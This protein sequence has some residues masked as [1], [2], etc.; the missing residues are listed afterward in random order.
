MA[1]IK[2]MVLGDSR[3]FKDDMKGVVSAAGS[4]GRGLSTMARAAGAAGLVLAGGLAVGMKKSLDAAGDF[5]SKMA[6]LQATTHG[7]N[8]QMAAASKLAIK[9]GADARLPAVSAGDAADAMLQLG[10]AGFSVQKSM[11]AARG[12]L[13]LAT[14]AETDGA[15]AAKV[16][17]QNLNAFGLK[18]KDTNKIVDEM[19]GFMNAT[20]TDFAA[21]ADS[22][23][24]TAAISH[25]VGQSF[26]DTTTQ[27]TILSQAGIEGSQAGTGLRTML[28]G[29]GAEG[30]KASK[31]FKAVGV[32]TVDSSGRFVGMRSVIQQLTP[33][34]DKMTS[35]QRLTFLQT[36]F[37]KTAMNQANIVLSESIAKYDA[38]KK[39][40]DRKG[41]ADKLAA[42]HMKGYKGALAQ[43]GS[44]LE[45]LEIT[46][47]TKFL[48]VATRVANFLTR[49]ASAPSISVAIHIAL[50]GLKTIAGD[51][52]KA[53]G[54]AL[55]GS[56]RQVV[57]GG[58]SG[59]QN[60]R[61][62]VSQ[63]LISQLENY[64]WQS[65]MFG[66]PKTI[67]VGGA[68][69]KA[70]AVVVSG[71][72]IDSMKTAFQNAINSV[73][74]KT[75]GATAGAAI[76]SAIVITTAGFDKFA[77]TAMA[78]ANAHSGQFAQLGALIGLKVISTLL[79]PSFWAQHWQLI[80]GIAISVFPIGRFA[81]LGEKLA[82]GAFGKLGPLIEPLIL[83]ALEKLPSKLQGVG[84]KLAIAFGELIQNAAGAAVRETL[85]LGSKIIDAISKKF[86]LLG[87][88]VKVLLNTAI[89]AAIGG[90]ISAAAGKA[91]DL[92][93]AIKTKIV[94][95]Y[96]DVKTAT[97][98]WI[99]TI[100]A[101]IG[102]LP[103][104]IVGALG[105]LSSLLYNEGVAILQGFLDGM[106]SKFIDVK[107]FLTHLTSM[108]PSWKG[109]LE[110][111]RI[112]LT[113]QGQAIIDGL[114]GGMQSRLP[115]L[116]QMVKGIAASVTAALANSL[117]ASR[118]TLSNA[119]S[120]LT[121]GADSAF[122][123]LASSVQT[124]TEKIISSMQ[125]V[126]DQAQLT[127]ALISAQ[128]QLASAQA[129]PQQTD[130]EKT[131][132]A[133]QSAHDQAGLD[134]A[135]NT[136]FS[137]LQTAQAGGDPDAILAAQQAFAD[138][139]YNLQVASLNKQIA[140]ETDANTQKQAIAD[141]AAAVATA[142]QAIIDAKTN[143]DLAAQ[144]AA[145]RVQLDAQNAV[146]Q[147]AF[148]TALAA[149]QAHLAKGHE[150]YKQANAAILK[151]FNKYIPDYATAGATL[152]DA[153]IT[154]L[155]NSIQNAA[156]KAGDISGTKGVGAAIAGAVGSKIPHLATG[157]L[158]SQTGLAVVHAGET[159]V[160][161]GAGGGNVNITINGYVSDEH[162]EQMRN[163]LIRTGRRTSGGVLGGF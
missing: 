92:A 121:S 73:D 150:T 7:T 93:N 159:V 60:T 158:I 15:T 23:T 40:V 84:L 1:T 71:G 45:T 74:W 8:A 2:V 77:N 54:D 131:L 82:V 33:V 81:G 147:T 154:A 106:K 34:F 51:A 107:N 62:V 13:L 138:A 70:T 49:I 133:L 127:N 112:M 59:H 96:N 113:P 53:I 69:G 41:Q 18:A 97:S 141:A 56:S 90:L 3:Q 20:G 136:A 126:A 99:S 104:R 128:S 117:K 143:A 10:K 21:F 12:T 80:G 43:L 116:M 132:A 139:Q 14:A 79:D 24:Y 31:T 66:N 144:A 118:S 123:T 17:T 85:T 108:I 68:E 26:A 156:D 142:N 134:Q 157:G 25:T 78:W 44:A 145:E 29:L 5:Q 19:A 162:L 9:L 28:A 94:S 149:L 50:Q 160:P 114:H 110:A 88:L 119:W 105:D 89:V 48:P 61:V 46:M 163:L 36:A 67:V 152:G 103:G 98:Q 6:V 155:G 125:A 52:Q 65:L 22:L 153:F 100:V 140:A 75:V 58:S 95:G 27:L 86:G 115:D 63:G 16:V 148:D 161:A 129:G 151:L 91:E 102:G 47:G 101:W 37:G 57:I 76:G 38:A 32:D 124:K 72:L 35:S 87:P 122:S 109:P 135:S 11:A 83:G 146:K 42:A 130:A 55:F 120:Q 39:A 137:Q 64:D 111:D 4:A 30:S